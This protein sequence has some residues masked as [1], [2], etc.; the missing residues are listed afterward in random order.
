[1]T[2]NTYGGYTV[3]QLREFIRHHYDAE[4]GGDNIDELTNDSSASVKIVRDL[5]DAIEPQQDGEL[6]RPIARWVYNAVRVNLDLLHGICSE[7]GCPQG[8]DVATWL[9]ARLTQAL[10]PF[11]QRVQPWMLACFGAK[12]SADKLE[13]NH[14]FFEEAGELVQACG[15]TREEAHALVDYTWSRPVGEPT[16]EV[17]G[18][19]VT[20]A[21]LCLANGLD[22]HA[23]GETELAR[24]NVPETVAKIRAKQAAK[25]KHSP[26]PEAPRSPA[27]TA[28]AP[29]EL[30]HWFEMFLTNVCEISDRNSPD[31]E[32]DAIVATLEELR[33][34]A[35]NAIEQ[36][37]SYAAPARSAENVRAWETDDG[38]VITDLQKQQ[39]LHDGGASA[40]SVQ[41]YAHA[42]YRRVPAHATAPAIYQILTEEGAW[43][44]TTRE[45]YDRTKSDP[46]LARVV[47]S[48][49]QPTAQAVGR[50]GLTDEQRAVMQDAVRSISLRADELKESNTALD[51]TWC[52]ADEKAA[53]EA[54]ARLIE[55]LHALL[56]AHP[57]QTEPR[58]VADADLAALL[59]GTYYMDPP[60]GGDISLLE[61]LRRMAKD[62]ARHRSAAAINDEARE[63]LYGNLES[64]QSA[65]ELADAAGNCSQARGLEAVE[66]Q[67]RRLFS[68]NPEPRNEVASN[69]Q[70]D[71]VRWR[72]LMKNGEPEVFVERTQRRAIQR[73][74]PVAFSSPNLTGGDRFDTP[75]EMW[76]KRYVMFAWW[77]RE[78]EHRKFIE[79]V[80]AIAA[81]TIQ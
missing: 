6:L 44:D 53:Y 17:G 43:L 31:G 80:D 63:F 22:M 37:I 57:G 13:R 67:I 16:Q 35:L 42:L 68:G 46:A 73:T 3:D 74:Q 9:R 66:Y 32:P 5:L 75:S 2:T 62:A 41:P 52:D 49:P 14:R 10:A 60:D 77:A 47:Y 51:G 18:V 39:A 27:M 24:I 69:D 58:T 26:L 11:Q 12:I 7:F 15:M 70:R 25:P 30:P 81:G 20:L 34:C 56:A 72:A 48:A 29:E 54:E 4:H 23:A 1:M 38:R 50:A 59:P 45:Y 28:G 71:G 55:R 78:N 33:N 36:C 79:A 19:M 21:A 8:E 61:Q 40:S 76:V 65:I 64:I